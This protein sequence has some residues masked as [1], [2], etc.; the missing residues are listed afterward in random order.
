MSYDYCY[1]PD[2]QPD[3]RILQHTIGSPPLDRGSASQQACEVSSGES[4]F[5]V[6]PGH[7]SRSFHD[8]AIGILMAREARAIVTDLE[9]RQHNLR[10]EWH[11]A[12][13]T[14]NPT[15]HERVLEV[16]HTN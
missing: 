3:A 13:Y 6:F 8:M 1:W 14:A 4:A 12:V 15:V 11:G 10:D 9:S 5:S 16:L 2:A 7:S